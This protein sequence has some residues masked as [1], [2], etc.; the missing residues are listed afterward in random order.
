MSKPFSGTINVDVRDSQP[1]H[2]DQKVGEGQIH[3]QPGTFMVA[4]KA[5]ASDGTAAPA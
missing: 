4:G 3:T 1:D 5:F 2:G